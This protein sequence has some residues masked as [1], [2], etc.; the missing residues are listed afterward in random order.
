M[1]SIEQTTATP[2]TVL[3]REYLDRLTDRELIALVDRVRDFAYSLEPTPEQ[4][5]REKEH[6]EDL[7]DAGDFAGVD[8]FIAQIEQRVDS[9]NQ[10]TE[11]LN[12][13]TDVMHERAKSLRSQRNAAE[14]SL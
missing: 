13:L 2:E 12:G 11:L 9:I 7:A 5:Q 3:N 14:S 1:E 6:V 4:V 10:V 8:E